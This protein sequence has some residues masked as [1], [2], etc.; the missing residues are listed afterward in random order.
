MCDWMTWP[1]RGIEAKM[2]DDLP[3]LLGKP[4]IVA[5]V[6]Q[7]ILDEC[8]RRGWSVE[9]TLPRVNNPERQFVA[10]IRD[11][12]G[13]AIGL[14]MSDWSN[15]LAICAAFRSAWGGRVRRDQAGY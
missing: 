8:E 7:L 15:V 4:E 9:A 12:T 2:L 6:V 1:A 13:D 14:G 11:A 5:D 10:H 3:A